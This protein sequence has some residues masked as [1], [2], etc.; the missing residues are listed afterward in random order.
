[1]RRSKLIKRTLKNTRNKSR[2]IRRKKSRN[3]RKKI[4]RGG[5]CNAWADEKNPGNAKSNFHKLCELIESNGA[6]YT[7]PLT[8][9]E[10]AKLLNDMVHL[11][12]NDNSVVE[13]IYK[14]MRSK[15]LCFLSQISFYNFL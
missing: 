11:Y 3:T 13:E 12:F 10:S 9:A 14:S 1:M 6:I 5:D 15:D 7:T 4:S 2:A 8:P